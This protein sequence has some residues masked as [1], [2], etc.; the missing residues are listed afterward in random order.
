MATH[1]IT[2]RHTHDNLGTRHLHATLSAD[3]TL[4]IEGQDVGDGVE[5]VFGPGNREY[6]WAWTL[7]PQAAAQL[8]AALSSG[9]DLLSALAARF[10]NEAAADLHS[11][12][13]EHSIQYDAWSRMGD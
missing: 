4:T 6:E 9:D 3:G 8:A 1:S 12:L 5:Q 7:R 2:L 11:F 10:S 13:D